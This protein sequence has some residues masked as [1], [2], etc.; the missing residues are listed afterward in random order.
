MSDSLPQRFRM[1]CERLAT[2]KRDS[3]GLRAFHPL[4]ADKLAEVM[5]VCIK[6]PADMALSEEVKTHLSKVDT[7]FGL[8]L[9]LE[10]PTILYNPNQSPA[11][12]ESTVMHELAHIILEHPA[13]TL[14]LS[15][16]RYSRSYNSRVEK[17]A[18]YLGSCLQ[19]P[20][21]GVLW[22]TQRGMKD[23]AIAEYFGASFQIVRWRRNAVLFS[24][25]AKA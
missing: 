22:A 4:P 15:E 20:K 17:E 3:L 7:W 16:G 18:A 13:G 14:S 11:R 6:T 1:K 19:I 9:E 8:L 12:Y 21:R 5:Q 25:S 23:E 2:E 10:H 24:R